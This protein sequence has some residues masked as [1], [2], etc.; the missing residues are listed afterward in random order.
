MTRLM[1][2]FMLCQ[3]GVTAIEYALLGS[4][5]AIAIVTGVSTVGTSLNTVFTH[6]AG[7]FP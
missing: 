2:R 5:V 3:Q 4:G 1:R 7:A 6:I